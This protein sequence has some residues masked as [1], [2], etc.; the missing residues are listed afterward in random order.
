MTNTYKHLAGA[1]FLTAGLLLMAS[2]AQVAFAR[3]ASPDPEATERVAA[4][5]Q[6]RIERRFGEKPSLTSLVRVVERRRE[7]MRSS[8]TVR[9]A[10]TGN[11]ADGAVLPPVTVNLQQYSTWLQFS[12]ERGPEFVLDAEIIEEQLRRD[13]VEKF[14]GP[15]HAR[16][17]STETK[18]GL[19][20]ATMT[21][22]TRAGY[23]HDR[24][25]LAQD[26]ADAFE[27]GETGIEFDVT[28]ENAKVFHD[29]GYWELLGMGRSEFSTSPWGRKANVRKAINQH[30]HGMLIKP[31]ETFSFNATLG[32]PVSKSNGWHDSLIIVNGGELEPAPGGGI[33]QAA[34]TLYR[35]IVMSGLPIVVRKPHSLYV[36]YYERFGLGLDATVFPKRQDLT[37]TNDTGDTVL[38]QAYTVGDEA[39]VKLFGR[40]DGRSI[41]MDGPY[42][43]STAPAD[44]LVN[45]R[46]VRSNEIVWRY[47]VNKPTGSE[48][49][50]IV[51][52]YNKGVPSAYL[53][54][55]YA[56]GK[57]I[58]DL[59]TE[60]PLA[61]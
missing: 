24:A 26:I 61:L 31:G 27:D 1:A 52:G 44:M 33:C 21:G 12:L 28:Y 30:L 42:F 51:S 14:N 15:L 23:V 18:Y 22:S 36:H 16:V 32:G 9:F 49:K 48:T 17:L 5:L 34:T 54:K 38:I 58:A 7:L 6:E 29:G 45:G 2:Y 20:H 8:V 37:F 43:G 55:K 50:L 57:G 11:G 10:D 56:D 40:R 59:Y 41:T 4:R 39:V 3:I 13:N 47:T 46:A 19:A 53:A 60:P 25:Q 35:A